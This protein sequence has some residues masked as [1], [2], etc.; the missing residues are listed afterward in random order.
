MEIFDLEQGMKSIA[1][2]GHV[3]NCQEMTCIQAG[4]NIVKCQHGFK[5]IYFW[6]KVFGLKNDYY[7]AYGL[8]ETD[9]EFPSK[10][11]FFAGDKFEFKAMEQLTEELANRV[12]E[13]CVERPF[14]GEPQ[15]SIEGT[16]AVGEA[17]AG[18]GEGGGAEGET[19]K[20]RRLTEADRLA[21]VIQE[22]D[23]DTAVV[24]KGAHALNENHAVIPNRAFKGL[25]LT[26]AKDLRRYVHFRP[27][28]NVASLRALSRSDVQ[29]YSD[30][31]DPLE[32][33]LP[34][35]CWALRRDH[36]VALIT[37]RSLLWPGYT[38][39]H[40]PETVKFGGLYFGYGLKER[41]LPFLL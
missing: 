1:P 40:I 11:F 8:R 35:G 9:F 3:M 23:F 26:E 10:M 33:D 28:A 20:P 6:G 27:P 24:P 21:Q 14:S 37:V 12:I 7:I 22:I 31:L 17:E 5:E 38:A 2:S 41:D 16:P 30:F 15:Q 36:S 13:L 34:R 4:L 32:C 39:F 29:F 25:G 18:D 19:D